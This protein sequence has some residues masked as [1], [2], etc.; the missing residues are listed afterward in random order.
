RRDP[1]PLGVGGTGGVVGAHVDS[2]GN[3]GERKPVVQPDRQSASAGNAGD[4]LGTSE[5]Q[6]RWQRRGPNDGRTLRPRLPTRAARPSRAT[7]PRLLPAQSG[8]TVV[9]TEARQ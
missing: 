4:W 7:A 6:R 2:P 1:C 8:Q 9:D 5:V 3:G